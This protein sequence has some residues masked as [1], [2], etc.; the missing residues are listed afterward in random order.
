MTEE[1]TEGW[2]E[3]LRCFSSMT[4]ICCQGDEGVEDEE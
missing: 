4:S 3:G 1:A 2:T